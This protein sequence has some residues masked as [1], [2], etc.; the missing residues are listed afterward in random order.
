MAGEGEVCPGW[1]RQ[2]RAKGRYDGRERVRRNSWGRVQRP[3]RLTQK[4][5]GL[6]PLVSR[7]PVLWHAHFLLTEDAVWGS[8]GTPPAHLSGSAKHVKSASEFH[9]VCS[10]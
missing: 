7:I 5:A 3:K 8:G 10:K 2:W 6:I 4:Q 1:G 9:G